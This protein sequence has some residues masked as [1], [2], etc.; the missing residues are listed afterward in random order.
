MNVCMENK[1]LPAPNLIFE[2]ETYKVYFFNFQC[3]TAFDI[4]VCNNRLRFCMQVQI[5]NMDTT[6][7]LC[8]IRIQLKCAVIT[9]YL[10]T[11]DLATSH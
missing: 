6:W 7:H 8:R 4:P 1:G 11:L 9:V 5:N 2:R 10:P 3:Q